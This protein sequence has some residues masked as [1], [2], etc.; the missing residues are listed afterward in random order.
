MEGGP[1]KLV[2][3]KKIEKSYVLIAAKNKIFPAFL[4]VNG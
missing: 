2:P 3:V 1:L 4:S